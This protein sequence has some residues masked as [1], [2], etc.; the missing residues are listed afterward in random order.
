M[1]SQ[2]YTALRATCQAVCRFRLQ[3]L[4]SQRMMITSHASH[5]DRLHIQRT[6]KGRSALQPL[7]PFRSR[8]GPDWPASSAR[9]RHHSSIYTAQ[10][11]GCHESSVSSGSEALA[12]RQTVA[13]A[14]RS[15]PGPSHSLE[16]QRDHDGESSAGAAPHASEERHGLSNQEICD[17]GWLLLLSPLFGGTLDA[18]WVMHVYT[19]Q[20]VL[21]KCCCLST[22]RYSI[23]D[24]QG[25]RT[26]GHC[27]HNMH[28]AAGDVHLWW[29]FPED[30][31]SSILQASTFAVSHGVM[32][33]K[34]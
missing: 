14:P 9:G 4:G 33:C 31:G 20:L 12:L 17:H 11:P 2:S 23:S 18:V 3:A 25:S 34:P 32:G 6:S 27:T 10:K 1:Q 21:C 15:Q 5:S 8:Q 19:A 26:E 30:V 16:H 28:L 24:E 22:C 13:S 7:L 29:L